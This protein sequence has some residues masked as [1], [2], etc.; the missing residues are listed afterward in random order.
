MM[1]FRNRKKVPMHIRRLHSQPLRSHMQVPTSNR[2][3]HNR[4]RS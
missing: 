4:C 3:Q 1:L 2:Q